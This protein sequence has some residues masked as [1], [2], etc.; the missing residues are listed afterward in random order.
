MKC[1]GTSLH[2]SYMFLRTPSQESP[3]LVQ[4]FT[5]NNKPKRVENTPE[6]SNIHHFP[7]IQLQ[8]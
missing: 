4:G 7:D 8:F 5:L 3:H 2:R 6:H 1:H